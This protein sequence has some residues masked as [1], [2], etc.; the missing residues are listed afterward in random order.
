MYFEF[1]FTFFLCVQTYA[2]LCAFVDVWKE[3]DLRVLN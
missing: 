3:N 1:Y 2:C